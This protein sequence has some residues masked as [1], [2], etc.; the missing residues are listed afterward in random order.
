MSAVAVNSTLAR[1]AFFYRTTIGKKVVMAITGL[2]LF[3]FLI[4]HMAGNLQFFLGREVLNDYARHLHELPVLL[5]GARITLLFSV[6]LHIVA[7][8]QLA[9]LQRTARP[10]TYFKKRSVGSSYASRTMYWSGPIVASFVIYHLLHLTLGAVHPNYEFLNA[11]DNLVIGFSNPLVAVFYIV[12]MVLLGMHLYHG[13]WSMFQSIGLA[14]PRY[15]PTIKTLTRAFT[16]VLMAG[17]LAVPVA[18]LVGYYP[19]FAKV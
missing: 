16:V 17:F 3:G 4:G 1:G 18:V 6:M 12:S 7:A 9:Q 10:V 11:Y 15:T 13:V 19:D 14:H 2:V 5:W 8:V